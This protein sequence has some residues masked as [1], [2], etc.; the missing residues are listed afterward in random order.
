M[1][2]QKELETALREISAN[3]GWKLD[4]EIAWGYFFY[5]TDPELLD[6]LG[7]RLA[8]DGYRRVELVEMQREGWML[9][10]ERI[11]TMDPAALY[12]RNDAMSKLAKELGVA[13][14]D[15]WDVQPVAAKR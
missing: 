4:G 5:D 14:Y 13:A 8:G 10:L 1:Q 15:G 11:E 12:A 2:T 9:R 3:T 7:E 6:A